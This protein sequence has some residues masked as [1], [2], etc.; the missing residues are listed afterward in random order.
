MKK[1][2]EQN[3]V[4]GGQ[5][6]ILDRKKLLGTLV[7]LLSEIFQSYICLV[8]DHVEESRNFVKYYNF[9]GSKYTN[10]QTAKRGW[11]EEKNI[12]DEHTYM[13]KVS[14]DMTACPKMH[15]IESCRLSKDD[16]QQVSLFQ[17]K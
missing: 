7:F 9:L 3:V 14:Y 13:S 15:M 8:V 4:L 10:V 12:T 2:D 17:N 5:W 16:T 1:H 6:S 11:E